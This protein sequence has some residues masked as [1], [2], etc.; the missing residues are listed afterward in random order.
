M[1]NPRIK[2][3]GVI[4]PDLPGPL[5]LAMARALEPD[6][7]RRGITAAE[8]AD[9]VRAHADVAAGQ[10]DLAA[11]LDAW[12]PALARTIKRSHEADSGQDAPAAEHTIR[13]DEIALA[14]DEEPPHDAPTLEAHA[15]PSEAPPVDAEFESD[16]DAIASA[17][18]PASDG[19]GDAQ[20]P[21][22]PRRAL[23]WGSVLVVVALAVASLAAT[24]LGTCAR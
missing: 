14:F 21:N 20:R 12:R 17:L 15:L 13:Y 19:R 23:V 24:A 22:A 5:L 3:L 2:P 9:V 16:P 18:P 11:L 10:R 4:R 8:L 6:R 1:R 7:E